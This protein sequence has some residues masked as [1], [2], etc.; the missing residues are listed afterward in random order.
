[1]RE[2]K[3]NRAP[4]PRGAYSQ[5]IACDQFIFTAGQLP[6]NPDTNQVV[7]NN[8]REQAQQ[9]FESLEHILREEGATL[10]N[11]LK[12]T[13]YVTDMDDWDEINEV[14]QTFF[15]NPPLPARTI[16]GVSELH[17]N[18]KLEV[19]AVALK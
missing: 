11:I 2:I 8:V 9:V 5:A 4:L 17:Y 18:V 10:G 16:V 3:T 6:I 7:S 14:Y 1:M 12:V 15:S 13:I 19:D